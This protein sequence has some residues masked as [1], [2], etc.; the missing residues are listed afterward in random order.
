MSILQVHPG[1]MLSAQERLEQAARSARTQD[2]ADQLRTASSA[3]PGAD[4]VSYLTELGT[5]WEEELTDWS[6]RVGNYAEHVLGFSQELQ[7]VDESSL[8]ALAAVAVL[9]ET[10][11]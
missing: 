2:S 9:L 6:A 10:T 1:Q 3:V 7:A 8:V 5:S 11:P 4:S